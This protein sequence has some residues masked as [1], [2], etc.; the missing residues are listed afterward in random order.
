[1]LRAAILSV[2]AAAFLAY[3]PMLA[4]KIILLK[5][6]ELDNAKPREEPRVK[7]EDEGGEGKR[8]VPVHMYELATRLKACHNNQLEMLGLY[9]GAVGVAVAARVAPDTLNRLT[10]W[11]VK[12]RLAYALAYAAP[13]VAG[14]ALRSSA[15][16]A[17][18]VSCIMI[19]YAAADASA[20]LLA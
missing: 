11:Y 7:G 4:R 10:G 16:I 3:A 19:F 17:A 15:F 2:P 14:G 20:S 18:S 12:S 1:M 5:Y 9:A 6:G 8:G 13:Q